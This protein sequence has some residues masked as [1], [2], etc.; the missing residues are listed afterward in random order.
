MSET[1]ENAE[2]IPISTHEAAAAASPGEEDA[3]MPIIEAVEPT[4]VKSEIIICIFAHGKDL[5]Y[6]NLPNYNNKLQNTLTFTLASKS[7]GAMYGL[8]QVISGETL[9]GELYTKLNQQKKP[10]SSVMKELHDNYYSERYPYNYKEEI[11]KNIALQTERIRQP[12]AKRISNEQLRKA[13]EELELSR[14]L[15][16]Q[17]YRDI[18]EAYEKKLVA[19]PRF[20][21]IDREYN[22]EKIDVIEG[23]PERTRGIFILD[24][25]NP[26][27]EAQNDFFA[28]GEKLN[29][30]AS[31]NIVK[32][33]DIL[34]ICYLQY[35]F[36]Y[37]AI[38]DFACRNS[39]GPSCRNNSCLEEVCLNCGS[40]RKE[41]DDGIVL[42]EKYEKE[43]LGGKLKN[44]NTKKRKNKRNKKT[45][46]KT[47]KKRNKKTYKK[48]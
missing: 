45:Y 5:C 20:I 13:T 23:I 47:Y 16:I 43:H 17:S 40:N 28:I 33:S 3:T 44:K 4:S 46:K 8:S 26:K 9:I 41:L 19:N 37:V 15:V 27:N 12:S 38:F 30:T 10:V 21:T 11:Q 18:L 22:I 7:Q 32:L 14:P 31:T 29:H 24:I 34:N 1:E 35:D 42:L 39:E 48:N 2:Q 25:R 6:D 36:D